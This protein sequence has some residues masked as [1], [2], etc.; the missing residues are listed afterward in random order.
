MRNHHAQI[1]YNPGAFIDVIQCSCT[2]T[3]SAAFPQ[4]VD[5]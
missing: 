1:I 2:E 3:F 5:W 4:C